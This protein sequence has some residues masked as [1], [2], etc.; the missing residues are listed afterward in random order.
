ME[1]KIADR[2]G[3]DSLSKNFKK[4]EFIIDKEIENYSKIKS[5]DSLEEYINYFNL[6][7]NKEK[8]IYEKLFK[9]KYEKRE[10]EFLELYNHN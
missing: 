6:K 2:L 8:N 1:N 5:V 3:A 10:N 4:D 9:Y 7:E